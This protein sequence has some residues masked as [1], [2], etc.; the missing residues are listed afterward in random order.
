MAK[1]RIVYR[2]RNGQWV[3][4]KTDSERVSSIHSTQTE[5]EK[6]AREMLHTS[7][8]GELIIKGLDGK[9]RSKSTV[10]LARDPCP[11]K[12]SYHVVS[13]SSGNWS[14]KKAGEGRACRVFPTRSDAI[15]FARSIARSAARDT[16]SEVVIHG[17]DG[18]IRDKDSYGHDPC[19]PRCRH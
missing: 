15:S 6:S 12:Y 9:V 3:N 2:R 1:N 13:R 7:S 14:V 19:P 8:G 18:R 11:P 10:L 17:R 16:C 4:K 5:A